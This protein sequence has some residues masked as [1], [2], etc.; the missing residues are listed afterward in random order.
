MPPR[1]RSPPT[2]GGVW[3]R[4]LNLFGVA[5]CLTLVAN[6]P[7]ES[8]L[9]GALVFAIGLVGRWAILRHRTPAGDYPD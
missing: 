7:W 5:G 6:L 3:P 4:W 1:I 9:A 8:V 2:N